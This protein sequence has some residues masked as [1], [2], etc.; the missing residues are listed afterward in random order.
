MCGIL[1]LLNHNIINYDNKIEAYL[2]GKQRGPEKSSYLDN[3]NNSIF[4][5]H[6]LAINGLDRISL[7]P[8]TINNISIICNGEIYNFKQLYKTFNIIPKTNSDCEVIIHLYILFGIDVTLQ[9]LDG[10]FGFVLLDKRILDS[11]KMFVSRDPFGVRPLYTLEKKYISN[12]SDSYSDNESSSYEYNDSSSDEY[13]KQ[14][15][16]FENTYKNKILNNTI[17]CFASEIKVLEC[18]LKDNNH[19]N[20]Y[21]IVH[22]KPGYYSKLNYSNKNNMWYYTKYKQYYNFLDYQINNPYDNLLKK[23]LKNYLFDIYYYLNLAVEKRVRGTTDRPV[24]CLLS[25]GL[26]SSLIA[27]LVSK[28]YN[29]QLETYSIGFKGS[30]DLKNARLVANHIG[31]KH[32]EFIVTEQEFLDSIPEVIKYVESYDTTTIRASVGNY[33]IGKKILKVSDAKV[34]FNGDGSDELAGGYIYFIKAPNDKEFNKECCRLLNNI[35]YFDVLRSDKSISSHGLEPRTPFLDKQFVEKYFSIPSKIRDPRSLYN[36]NNDLWKIHK[37]ACKLPE[38]LLL[39][40]A[41]QLYS[42]NLLPEEVLW[43]SKEA[44]SDGVSGN[45]GS[46]YEIIKKYTDNLDIDLDYLY[47]DEVNEP[48]TNEQKYYRSLFNKMFPHSSNCIPYFWMPKYVN[49]TDA[50]ARSLEMYNNY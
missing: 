34:I 4:Y 21:S 18:I 39:R 48:T 10:V 38:K 45:N 35:Y 12:D 29:K 43:R 3:N 16:T 19:K 41:F 17:F 23:D 11:Q 33:L 13:I 5:F 14:N 47:N 9:L 2:K 44:F 7:Q 26:D 40:Y 37:H 31:S 36:E 30:D 1:A 15:D 42:P 20:N 46:W 50:S 32:T 25:G 8:I 27:S 6:R 24:A 49:A 28:F 22:F